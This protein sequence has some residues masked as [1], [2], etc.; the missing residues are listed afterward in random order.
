MLGAP[1]VNVWSTTRTGASDTTSYVIDS[2]TSLSAPLVAGTL[3]LLKAQYP[4]ES[5]IQH[6]N[7]ILSSVDKIPS[8]SGKCQTGGRLNLASALSSTSTAPF[9]DSFANRAT[10]S[11]P[12][13]GLAFVLANNVTATKESGEPNHAGLNG[14]ASVWWKWLCPSTGTYSI[15]LNGSTFGTA[16]AVYTGTAVNTLTPIVSAAASDDNSS[17]YVN[18]SALAGTTYQIAVD[19]IGTKTGTIQM[20]LSAGSLTHT[21][22]KFAASTATRTRSASSFTCQVTGGATWSVTFERTSDFVTW[23]SVGSGITLSGGVGTFTD[24]GAIPGTHYFYRAASSLNHEQSQNVVGYTDVTFTSP[25]IH[26][27]VPLQPSNPS[28]TSLFPAP[29]DGT[30][31]E[32]HDGGTQN[33]WRTSSYSSLTGSWSD[34]G[35]NLNVGTGFV[36]LVSSSVDFSWTGEVGRGNNENQ[37]SSPWVFLGSKFPKKSTDLRRPRVRAYRWR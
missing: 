11:L 23:S 12:D 34:P 18:F 36:Y 2:G 26:T 24:S 13:T 37:V 14:G 33:T 16:I 29:A 7:R 21:D 35:I 31:I 27:A 1:G 17:A 3:A 10:I 9:N 25:Y 15:N 8:L 6:I 20:S 32:V 28:I 22:L 5:Y 19:S 4:A 30:T